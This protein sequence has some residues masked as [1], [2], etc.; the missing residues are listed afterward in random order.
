MSSSCFVRFL[1]STTKSFWN[2]LGA[3]ISDVSNFPS[4]SMSATRIS[5]SKDA[6]PRNIP[7]RMDKAL[8][9]RAAN[10]RRLAIITIVIM[11]EGVSVQST[12]RL[13]LLW[14][15]ASSSP[16]FPH[17]RRFSPTWPATG[18]DPPSTR[19]QPPQR[20]GSSGMCSSSHTW[21]MKARTRGTQLE[22]CGAS[23]RVRDTW[24]ISSGSRTCHSTIGSQAIMAME[25]RSVHV[26]RVQCS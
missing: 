26:V 24:S 17:A 16:V 5:S 15:V 14:H 20:T 9:Q 18:L 7:D 10:L 12:P 22:S 11:S 13:P 3:W 6:R 21:T 4:S 19:S 23:R 2:L 1:F 25:I 8:L